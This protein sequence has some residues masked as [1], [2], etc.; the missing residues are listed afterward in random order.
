MQNINKNYFGANWL[1]G[2]GTAAGCGGSLS[3]RNVQ[4]NN[5]NA[6]KEGW[7]V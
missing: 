7:A 3:E 1:R 5:L 2:E 4:D 6:G